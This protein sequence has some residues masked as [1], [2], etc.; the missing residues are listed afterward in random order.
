MFNSDCRAT[1][2]RALA[3]SNLLQNKCDCSSPLSLSFPPTLCLSLSFCQCTLASPAGVWQLNISLG[4]E[5]LFRNHYKAR[6]SCPMSL[7]KTHGKCC[8]CLC[9]CAFFTFTMSHP[10]GALWFCSSR[11]ALPLR[12][13]PAVPET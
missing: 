1:A 5:A 2:A 10:S 11:I 12:W 3:K 8:V 9:V 4:N 7:A 13:S 6:K